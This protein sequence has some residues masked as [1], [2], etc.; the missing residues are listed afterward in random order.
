MPNDS[1]LVKQPVD[2]Q[3]SSRLVK[4]MKGWTKPWT[5]VEKPPSGVWGA[6]AQVKCG[7]VTINSDELDLEFTVNFDDDL[8]PNDAEIIVYNLS[9]NTIN[10]LKYNAE[11]SITAG[12]KKDTGVIFKGYIDS[13]KTK[14]DMVDKITT[15]NCLDDIKDHTITSISFASGTKASYILKQLLNK[16][17]LPIAVFNVRRDHTYDSEQTVDGDLMENIKTFSEVCGVSTY[18]NNGK[19][20]CRY[21]KDGDNISFTVKEETGMIGSPEMFEEEQTAEDFKEVV[22]G[23]KIDMLLQHR[24][25]T[26]AI[27][28]MTSINATNGKYR[29]RKGTHTFNDS[30]AIT[31]IEVI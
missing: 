26:A 11:I 13:V 1:R 20:Y 29:V 25:T 31:E 9:D 12:Y 17:G 14:R 15:I 2:K 3:T 21:I 5:T 22:N 16:T 28:D 30:G 10:Q 19:I 7:N 27:I 18:V 23:Y 4:A 24:M 8:E 6:V